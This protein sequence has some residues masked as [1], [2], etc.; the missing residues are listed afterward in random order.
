MPDVTFIPISHNVTPWQVQRRLEALEAAYTSVS[1][2]ASI[3]IADAATYFTGTQTEAALAELAV[4]VGG[5]TST[6]RNYSSN[7]TVADN[8]TLMVA[9]GKL[10]A[11]VG[12]YQD[13]LMTAT[14]TVP[15][16]AAGVNTVLATVQLYCAYD[17]ATS[18]TTICQYM[19]YCSPVQYAPR[20]NP[21]ATVTFSLATAGAIVASGNGW[22]LVSADATGLFACT[23]T[24]SAD[25]TVYFRAITADAISNLGQRA[26]IVASNEDAATWS[27]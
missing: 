7:T 4:A 25:E 1:G 2:A 15:N 13:Q 11:R 24:D 10:D 5:A 27:A 20:Q 21:V 18:P 23:I 8:D 22:A 19:I 6:T 3:G 14:V 12:A 26:T 16:S 9:A 17:N